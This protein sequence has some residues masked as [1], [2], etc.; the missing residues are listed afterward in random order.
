MKV[1]SMTLFIFSF[2]A[3]SSL[4]SEA[5][6]EGLI[7]RD[8]IKGR[9]VRSLQKSKIETRMYDFPR[10]YEKRKYIIKSFDFSK[11]SQKKAVAYT[12]DLIKSKV[13]RP[14]FLNDKF[15]CPVFEEYA[16]FDTLIYSLDAD[17]WGRELSASAKGLFL[18]HL[19]IQLISGP[20]PF[21]SIHIYATLLENYTQRFAPRHSL[22]LNRILFDIE[23]TKKEFERSQD[24]WKS[25]VAST[26]YR[27]KLIKILSRADFN[28]NR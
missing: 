1:I 6:R 28:I 4:Y 19:K 3:S 24:F 21:L 10:D 2:S 15:T 23:I 25:V 5:K 11:I 18:D 22:E 9:L 26:E 27:L 12:F 16:F 14:K 8:Y 13:K 7:C 20:L 17:D